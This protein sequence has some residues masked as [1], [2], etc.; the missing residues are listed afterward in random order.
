M[1]RS[2]KL[3]PFGRQVLAGSARA[4]RNSKRATQI[5]WGLVGDGAPFKIRHYLNKMRSRFPL[6]LGNAFRAEKTVYFQWNMLTVINSPGKGM[7]SIDFDP[8]FKGK[9]Y[10]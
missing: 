9:R 10:I 6:M 3:S 2:F 4:G 8:M 1:R 7:F 5:I